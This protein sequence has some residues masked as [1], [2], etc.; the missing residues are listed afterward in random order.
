MGE[1]AGTLV[2][3]GRETRLGSG[4]GGMEKPL[5][6]VSSVKSRVFLFKSLLDS[7]KSLSGADSSKKEMI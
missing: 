1:T 6:S 4:D 2:P 7:L 5:C 3:S